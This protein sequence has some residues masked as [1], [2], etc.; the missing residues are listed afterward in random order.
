MYGTNELTAVHV[1]KLSKCHQQTTEL[2]HSDMKNDSMLIGRNGR[3][4][5]NWFLGWWDS[6]ATLDWDAVSGGCN[7]ASEVMTLWRYTNM[8]III[9]IF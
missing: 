8:F 2:K 1:D 5:K 7:V 6:T 9:I 3:I 4:K